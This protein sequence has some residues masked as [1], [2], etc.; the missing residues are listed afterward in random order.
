MAIKKSGISGIPFGNTASR[1]ASPSLGQPYFNG[2]VG[3]L[4]LYSS[5]GWQNIVQETP[6]VAS[7]TG[8]YNQSAGSG[9]F[10]VAGTNFVDGAIAYA[11][12]TNGVEY[13][14]TTTTYNSIVQLT[15]VFSNLSPAHEPYDIKITNPSNLFG[16]LPDAFYINDNPVWTTSS[17][18]LGSVNAG[19]VVSKTVAST[20]P[21][22]QT[23]TYA[24]TTGSLP[25]GL[26]LNTSTGAITG[27]AGL[28]S[29]DTT[30][31]FTVTASDGIN[32][33]V[34]RS[35]NIPVV[36]TSVPSGGT[37]TSDSTYY[38][39]TFT[40]AGDF[41]VDGIALSADV[42]I[43]G[44][45]GGGGSGIG[46][47]GPG[48]GGAGSVLY[49]SGINC[50]VGSYPITVGAGGTFRNS[51]SFNN[52]TNGGNSS[53]NGVIALGGGGG[54]NGY[55]YNGGNGADGGS[56]GGGPNGQPSGQN[57]DNGQHL[58]LGANL[59]RPGGSSQSSIAG[60]TL[61]AN[62]G[63]PGAADNTYNVHAGGG[64]GGAGQAGNTNQSAFHVRA[65]DGGDGTNTYSAWAS[66][67]STGSNGYYAG[68]GGGGNYTWGGDPSMTVGDWNSNFNSYRGHAGL[69]GGGAGGMGPGSF[70]LSPTNGTAQT[71][72]GAGAGGYSQSGAQGG[73][74]VV[75]VR[76]TKASVGG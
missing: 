50:S 23:I 66:A 38:Y 58:T 32:S 53:F 61:H 75:I 20:D 74:G 12:G 21:E 3:R 36:A 55:Q 19:S 42:L 52:G 13:Q 76:Y 59:G 10:T 24:L 26:S 28:I 2:E 33:P 5:N 40:G 35:F 16:L 44:G 49:K 39:R 46:W 15:T 51:N 27:T 56:G 54:G 47:T 30:Y 60:W 43:V 57:Y 69:G 73:S 14:A 8:T 22:S 63:G 70:T 72:G 41:V 64:G 11:V 45:G 65:G 62:A 18:S 37:L 68:G 34:S 67:T 48:G 6:G 7:A 9:T 31:T 29:S 17:G 25:A 71:G 1:P 4:E